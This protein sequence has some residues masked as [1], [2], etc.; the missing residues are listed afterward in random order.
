MPSIGR[1]RRFLLVVRPL[2]FGRRGRRFL[3]RNPVKPHPEIEPRPHVRQI[4]P[5]QNPKIELGEGG[6]GKNRTLGRFEAGGDAGEGEDRARLDDAELRLVSTMA[7]S[8]ISSPLSRGIESKQI[9]RKQRERERERGRDEK[10]RKGAERQW[11]P[12]SRGGLCNYSIKR[13][14]RN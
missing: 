6:E 12:N 14:A 1:R 2:P 13:Y 8:S 9:N 5:A 3:L 10:K 7:S 4:K 11:S